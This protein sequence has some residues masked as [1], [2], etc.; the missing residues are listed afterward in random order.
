MPKYLIIA[1]KKELADAIA[2]AIPGTSIHSTGSIIK[3]DYTIVWCSGHLLS[4]KIPEDYDP[5]YKEWKMEDLPIY[6]PNWEMK[7]GDSVPR[8]TDKKSRVAMIGKLLRECDMVIHAGDCDDEGQLIVDEILRWHNYRGPVKRLNTSDTTVV[9]LQ[10]ALANMQDNSIERQRDGWAAYARNVSDA[11]VGFNLTRAMTLANQG[12][13]LSIGRVQTPTLGMV[14][15]RDALIEGHSKIVYYDIE[16]NIIINGTPIPAQYIPAEDNPNLV[17]GRIL[18]RNY[19]QSVAQLMKGQTLNNIQVEKKE[20]SE[21]PPLPFNLTKLTT[22]CSSR[23]GINDVMAITQ[24]LRDKH[25]AITYN[26]TDCRY[27]GDEHFNQAPTTVHAVIR[28]TGINPP[29]LDTSI[30]SKCFDQSKITVHFAIIPT[31]QIVDMSK[32]SD[33]EKK[34]YLAIATRYMMQFLPPAR[35][36]RTILS[37]H[38]PDGGVLHSTSTEVISAGYLLLENKPKANTSTP[39][40]TIPAGQYIG[41]C[42]DA[43][44]VEKETKPPAR[45]TAATL[46][47]DMSRISKYVTDPE[48]KQLLLKKDKD[49]DGENGSIGTTATRGMIIRTLIDRGFLCEEQKHVISTEKGR[50][51]YNAMPDEFRLADTTAKWWAVQEDI[52]EGLAQPDTLISS[53]LSTVQHFISNPIPKLSYTEVSTLRQEVGKCPVC[54]NSVLEYVKGFACSK[55]NPEHGCK[56]Y[57]GKKQTKFPPLIGKTLTAAT[58]KRLLNNEAVLVKGIPKKDG[59]GKYDAELSIGIN[60]S[61]MAIWNLKLPVRTSLGKC[62]ACGGEVIEGKSGYGCRNFKHPTNPCHFYIGKDQSKFPPLAKHKI[63]AADMKKLLIGKTIAVK[64]IPKKNGSGTYDANFALKWNGVRT[65][66]DMQFTAKKSKKQNL[67]RKG[68]IAMQQLT[69]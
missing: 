62:P 33:S 22:Y 1:E 16:S 30:R 35:K 40:S 48:A 39:L 19:A 46:E 60:D 67:Q 8:G 26:R 61:G 52:R 66:W 14:V 13:T 25:K 5:R 59:T 28:N 49:R 68:V 23:Y 65:E 47:E 24:S 21:Q 2:D 3:G 15:A 17:D 57:I 64:N 58:M 27:L 12:G 11:L 50:Q 51:L 36:M 9:S 18:D 10:N 43:N 34:V 6:F 63:T 56:F 54:G 38:L 45:Y 55:F 20:V 7:I 29:T 31:A 41:Q 4:L 37:A 42:Q 69:I 32:L 44:I 53:V